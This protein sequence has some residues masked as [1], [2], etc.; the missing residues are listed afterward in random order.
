QSGANEVY[1]RLG[2]VPDPAHY[3]YQF[4]TP[5]SPDQVVTIPTTADGT[6]YIL[7]RGNSVPGGAA[8][9][10][11]QAVVV[12]LELDDITPDEG[13]DQGYV[14][15][16]ITGAGFNAGATVHLVRPGF[17]DV[18]PESYQ[19]VDG[20]HIVARFLFTGVPHGLYDVV[21]TNPDGNQVTLPY[22]FFVTT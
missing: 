4:Q 16:T 14:T 19:V 17:A 2:N 18:V 21:V 12:P 11:L 9:Y 5:L 6:Y 13:G 1:V 20:T 10:S 3:D 22:R 8:S 15:T 7:V